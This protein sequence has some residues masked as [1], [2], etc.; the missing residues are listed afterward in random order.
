MLK[1]SG[2][3]DF[4]R[5]GGIWRSLCVHLNEWE[6]A[7]NATS[8][9]TRTITAIACSPRVYDN[10]AQG[11]AT[12][13]SC[14]NKIGY[15]HTKSVTVNPPIITTLDLSSNQSEDSGFNLYITY[16]TCIHTPGYQNFLHSCNLV[17]F[18]TICTSP[19]GVVCLCGVFFFDLLVYF[20]LL[21][22]FPSSICF[23]FT[24]LISFP[25]LF[26]FNHKNFLCKD[27]PL[28]NTYLFK[29]L[30]SM[31]VTDGNQMHDVKR[32]IALAATRMQFL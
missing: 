24:I 22:C 7:W 10:V 17:V 25:N 16:F 27:K 11:W 19:L 5:S 26:Y 20:G 15:G 14:I 29:C 8:T 6:D 32:R 12:C 1:V 21:V 4:L 9:A 28:V 3:K 31:F 13:D 23:T 30:G 2:S 18:C